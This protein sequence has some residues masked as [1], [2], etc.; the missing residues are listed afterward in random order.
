[1]KLSCKFNYHDESE[2][3]QAF[4][5]AAKNLYNQANYI[6][7]KSLTDTGKW[8]R[9]YALCKI[10][11]T[12]KNLEGSINYHILKS[13]TNQQILKTLDQNW[14]SYFCS[15]K[16]WKKNPEKHKGMPRPPRFLQNPEFF[17]I[18]TNQNSQMKN[19][20]I[21]LSKTL[22]IPIPD[23]PGK[24]FSDYQ[25]I[26]VIPTYIPHHYEVEIV[27]NQEVKNEVLD[28]EKYASV[29]LGIRNL[30]AL[31]SDQLSFLIDGNPLKSFNQYYNKEKARLSSIKDHQNIK[32]YTQQL[33]ALE[34]RRKQYVKDYL[35]KASRLVI[36]FLIRN[37]IGN[38][39]VGLNRFW[40]TQ[41]NLGKRNNQTFVAIPHSQLI[42]YLKYKCELVGIKFEITEESYTSKCDGLA[43]EKL[44]KYDPKKEKGEEKEE[45]KLKRIWLGKRIK[46]GLF[47]SS[48]GKLI[49]ADINGALNTLRKVVGDSPFVKGL[50]NSGVLF[51]PS[52]IRLFEQTSIKGFV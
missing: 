31:I 12:I 47:Q 48:T 4:T 26:R 23:H 44:D 37:K 5:K 11:P 19:G 49:N 8:I 41:I 1:M 43:L 2:Q 38:L 33:Y 45:K 22:S 51:M 14:A 24:D 30:L 21:I 35:H 18:Y 27:Y 9:Y 16:E 52:R 36:N 32:G 10:L 40:K 28:Y 46:R 6:I 3:I 15:I 13:Q 7:K 17:L 25:Q 50:I 42:S 29:D 34:Q 39:V 20:K